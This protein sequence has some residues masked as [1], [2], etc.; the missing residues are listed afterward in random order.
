MSSASD[1]NIKN[2]KIPF[3][4][5]CFVFYHNFFLTVKTRNLPLSFPSYPLYPSF[6][7]FIS[8]ISFLLILYIL[9]SYPF[10]FHPSCLSFLHSYPLGLKL[11]VMSNIV[12][13]W[14]KCMVIRISTRTPAL[15]KWFRTNK[16]QTL[17]L[18]INGF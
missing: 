16:I 15:W 5:I 17:K 13:K 14:L 3:N 6:L 11:L 2:N 12:L 7:S 1:I 18:F 4:N 8:F 9:P 10:P